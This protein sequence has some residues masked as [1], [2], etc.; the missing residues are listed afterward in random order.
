MKKINILILGIV[1]YGL[2]PLSVFAGLKDDLISAIES[3][4]SAQVEQ[5][6]LQ[7]ADPNTRNEDGDTILYGLCEKFTNLENVKPVKKIIQLLLQYGADPNIPSA[8]FLKETPL[9]SVLQ[10]G[11]GLG[12][13]EVYW[14]VRLVLKPNKQ[15]PKKILADPN[16]KNGRGD[17]PLYLF[18]ELAEIDEL[19][20]QEK[21]WESEIMQFLLK[22]GANPNELSPGPNVEYEAPLHVFCQNSNADL[23]KVLL[24]FKPKNKNLKVNVNIQDREGNTPLHFV[25][26][27]KKLQEPD[28]QIIQLLMQNGADP[29]IKNKTGQTPADLAREKGNTEAIELIERFY[30]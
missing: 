9:T 6:F 26:D 22:A 16:L 19:V 28:R 14:F 20:Q 25:C 10:A 11:T 5:L 8:S 13:G 27:R 30:R 7:G 4:D 23:V 1:G 12:I 21:D 15:H 24:Q 3:Y 17:T 18:C 2:L 29:M